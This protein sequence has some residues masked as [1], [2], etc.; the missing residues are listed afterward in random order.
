[1]NSTYNFL[2][3]ALL[4]LLTTAV[5]AQPDL[6][7]NATQCQLNIVA[8]NTTGAPRV[9][10]Q[11][12]VTTT[13]HKE[14][15]KDYTDAD[16]RVSF[17]IPQGHSYH[18]SFRTFEDKTDYTDLEIPN[19]DGALVYD[20]NMNFEVQKRVFTLHNVFFDSNKAT[21]RPESSKALNE[22]LDVLVHKPTMQIAI[23][24]HTDDVG[25]HD[26]NMK[27]S[28]ERAQSVV[29]YLIKNGANA[30]NLRA[31]GYGETKPIASNET[32][33]GRQENRRTEV[34]VLKE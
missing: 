21:L 5:L 15:Y 33:E 25:E 27:L 14:I 18:I 2:T 32:P 3:S 23:N 17:L 13:T 31:E 8:A 24:G 11:I 6:K 10:E 19:V 29:N 26:A 20:F 4:A 22:L 9:G 1:M 7:P 34:K 28:Q 16:G 30:A 12:I